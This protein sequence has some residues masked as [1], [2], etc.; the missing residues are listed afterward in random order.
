MT[1]PR[2]DLTASDIMTR[3]PVCVEQAT[4]I[5]ELAKLFQ[6]HEIS[7]APVVDQGGALLGIVSKTDVIRTCLEGTLDIP[8]AFL[9][10]V[11]SEQGSEDL[12]VE[13]SEPLVS[14][15]DFMTEDPVTVAP[16]TDVATIAKLMA[17]SRIHRVVVVDDER[18]PIG[19][20]TSLDLLGVWPR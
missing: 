18:Y 13:M 9:F 3:D 4:S 15:E 10:D 5:R 11:L 12:A 6:D 8:P 16:G 1:S 14:V 19:I 2:A 20:V 17:E 7:G